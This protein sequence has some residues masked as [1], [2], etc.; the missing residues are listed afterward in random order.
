MRFK[1]K[2]EKTTFEYDGVLIYGSEYNL[3]L[4]PEL[5][6]LRFPVVGLTGFPGWA[7]AHWKNWTPI[8]RE[9]VYE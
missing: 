7:S 4:Q 6:P 9:S 8:S 2:Q 3:W 1:K 5:C